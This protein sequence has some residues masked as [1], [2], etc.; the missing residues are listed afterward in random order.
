M[1]LYKAL[2]LCYLAA[3]AINI[4][5][6]QGS[7][8]GNDNGQYNVGGGN[9]NTNG[10]GNL[11]SYN[12]NGN[13]AYNNGNQNGNGNGVYN[14]GDMNGNGNGRANTGS[15]NG[16]SNGGS[17]T[18]S[19]NGNNNGIGNTG[20]GNG[21]GNGN[22]NAGGRGDPILTGF[23]GRSFEFQGEV[24]KF[25]DILSE[26]FHLVS[27]KLKLGE[28]WNHNGTYM[29]GYGLQY[30]DH[31]V[32]IEI[33]PE[34]ELAVTMNG[35]Q[36]IMTKGET[37][38][39]MVPYVEGGEMVFLWQLHREGLGNAVEITTDLLQVLVWLTPAGT[40]DEG[41]KEQP[42]Y[43]NFDVALLGPPAGNNMAGIV[44]ETY[45]RMLAGDAVN[46]PS[47]HLFLADDFEF[48]GKGPET[49]YIVEG[50][51]GVREASPFGK[52]HKRVLI[53]S[54]DVPTLAF[55]L[56]AF[57]RAASLTTEPQT[58]TLHASGGRK[59]RFL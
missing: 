17:N 34:D 12:G 58:V 23:D 51:F 42:A 59:G 5:S 30:R 19:S 53:E 14:I 25:Y 13:G 28:M 44:G 18:G 9:G 39:E 36:L 45:N 56:R 6:G 43:L 54:E 57:G 22:G 1:K 27:T 48:H 40:V 10:V 49:D 26:R 2:L 32:T 55:P 11:G 46:D 20:S 47:S 29:E 37:E 41:G 21:N 35:E 33:T 4:A 16:N 24:G 8:N 31:Q 52:E 38:L 7:G 3:V 15:N 50:Y